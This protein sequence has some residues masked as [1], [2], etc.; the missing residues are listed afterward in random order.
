MKEKL[1][2]L[3]GKMLVAGS[4][5]VASGVALTVPAFAAM[6]ETLT[7]TMTSAFTQVQENFTGVVGIVAPIGIGIAGIFIVWKLG[8]KFFKS[9]TK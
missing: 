2:G 5:I 3:G 4:T 8:L 1:K 9:V 7:T 6:D